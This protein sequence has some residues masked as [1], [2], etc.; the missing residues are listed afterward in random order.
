MDTLSNWFLKVRGEC[1]RL[2]A[3]VSLLGIA[4]TPTPPSRL[5]QAPIGQ[6]LPGLDAEELARFDAGA[7]L[8]ATPFTAEAGVGPRFNE[9][10]CNACHTDPADGGTGEQLVVKATRF[11]GETCD[12]LSALGGDNLRRQVTPA[13][14]DVDG[15]PVPVPPQA[16]HS[17]RFTTPFVFGLGVVDAVP[18][19]TLR[20]LE[21]PEDRDGDGISGRLGR[22]AEG[23]PARFGRKANVADLATFV[24]EAFRFEMGLT[25][26]RVPDE[27]GAGAIPP[28]PEGVDPA[29][30]PEIDQAGYQ[31]VVDF[32]RLLA[33][34]APSTPATE[35]ARAAAERGRLLFESLGCAAC[36]VPE[37]QAGD[38][39]VAAISGARVRLYSD[40]LLHDM[41]AELAGPCTS[42]ASPT[43]YRTEPLMGLGHRTVF[44]HDGRAGRL[45]DAVLLHGG[46]AERTRDAFASLD[47]VTQEDLIRFLATL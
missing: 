43:E 25:T 1:H 16:T 42:G 13:L 27:G 11:D 14:A 6:P 40:M 38:H 21:D 15:G 26:P 34:P 20:A 39:P 23:R 19:E 17:G 33:P 44:L 4:C 46:E 29:A 45:I 18:W 35:A 36:H 5:V 32:V 8:F 10:A 41:G 47:R 9:N 2:L 7:E 12:P 31:R 30:E 24:D 37:L 22:D 28:V 3:L